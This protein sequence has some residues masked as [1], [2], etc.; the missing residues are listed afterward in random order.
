MTTSADGAARAAA[1]LR[2]AARDVA[3][4]AERRTLRAAQAHQAT[5]ASILRGPAA[6]DIH[7]P[8]RWP[9]RTHLELGALDTAPASARAHV[10][11]VLREWRVGGDDAETAALIVTELLTNALE[12]T[13]AH[14]R[15]DPVR[16]WMLGDVGSVVFLVWDS[17]MPAPV[18]TT[19]APAD[20]QG[21][22]LS[23][24]DSLCEQWGYYHLADQ[25][26]GKVVWALM[27]T[28]ILESHSHRRKN[29]RQPT[30][31][32]GLDGTP[33]HRQPLPRRPRG[34]QPWPGGSDQD[35]RRQVRRTA[36]RHAD[37]S[38]ARLAGSS[39]PSPVGPRCSGTTFGDRD[40][41]SPGNRVR[42]RRASYELNL[43]CNYDCDHCYLGEK[44]FAGL[45]WPSRQRLL[46]VMAE[47]GVLA[48]HT[49]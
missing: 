1:Q 30:G 35:R 37:R 34:R 29:T 10:R 2:D 28:A 45:D 27:R 38:R 46:D 24:V 26:L 47:A 12:T 18:L 3:L 5:P 13:W 33:A 11:A 9:L 32:G 31:D 22:G 14:H 42:V 25:P 43:G 36:G 7:W 16:L 6:R 49:I 19:P 17:T 39:R 23:L 48:R 8:E 21:R 44:L 41:G 20:E 40:Q 15:D 4:V